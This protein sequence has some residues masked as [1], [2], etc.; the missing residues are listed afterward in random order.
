MTIEEII[1]T[2]SK[3]QDAGCI[4]PCPRCGKMT[5]NH[6]VENNALSRKADI[7]ICEK[8]GAAEA[9]AEFNKKAKDESFD[10]WF[11]AEKVFNLNPYTRKPISKNIEFTAEVPITLTMQ[12]IDDIMST[13]LDYIT[14]WCKRVEVGEGTYL[15]EYASDQISRNGTLVFYDAESEDKWMLTLDRFIAGFKAA[16]KN[17]YGTD[18]FEDGKIEIG[19]IDGPAADAIVQYALFEE[20]MFG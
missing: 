7:Y 1:G 6:R 3:A 5:M 17:G 2:W 20:L 9:L 14:Y 15:G 8:C 10:S 11:I 18:W 16:V 4:L 13:A 19:F 12:D